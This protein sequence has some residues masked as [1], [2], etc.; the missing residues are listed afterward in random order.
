MRIT[1]LAHAAVLFLL[2]A[3]ARAL[4]D[5]PY[6][7]FRIPESS[8]FRWLVN[9]NFRRNSDVQSEFGGTR[10]GSS[11]SPDL[12][13]NLSAYHEK[14]ASAWNFSANSFLRWS[15]GQAR[16]EEGFFAR[17]TGNSTSRRDAQGLSAFAEQSWY[18]GAGRY[19]LNAWASVAADFAQSIVSDNEQDRIGS[20]RSVS[21]F[22]NAT[23]RYGERSSWSLGAGIGRVRSVYGVYDAWDIERRLQAN[24]RLQRPL[25][26][27]ARTRL[28]QLSYAGSGLFYAHERSSKY[29]WRE[30][31][32]IL[33]EDG[34][35]IGESL[36]AYALERLLE[37]E[38]PGPY[39]PRMKG[40]SMVISGSLDADHGHN[41]FDSARDDAVYLSDTLYF[42]SSRRFSQRSRIDRDEFLGGLDVNL[43]QPVGYRWQFG[44]RSSARY[45]AGRKRTTRLTTLAQ[46]GW[47]IAD[48]WSATST[49]R[50]SAASSRVNGVGGPPRWALSWENSLDYWLEDAWSLSLTYSVQQEQFNFSRD[51]T[52]PREYS[53][54]GFIE[55]GLTYRPAGRF[56]MP[57]LGIAEHLVP[58]TR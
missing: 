14:D 57:E 49:M 28:A 30:L 37:G 54:Y 18:P 5:D 1:T 33:H 7:D 46:A 6:A 21:S 22:M 9:G 26:T 34:A 20:Q 44:V 53:R 31:E 58:G 47:S 4:A 19:S 48:R 23:R 41:D 25:S 38:R 10:R 45:G 40:M 50:H 13:T 8:G 11:N 15:R 3:P 55:L 56:S 39:I 42:S 52:G 27:A 17:R 2:L 43:Q 29:Y 12:R 32:R 35:L 51:E 24:G 36:D 16:T